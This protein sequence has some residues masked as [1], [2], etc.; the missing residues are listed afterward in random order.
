MEH[1]Q[2]ES[3]MFLALAIASALANPPAEAQPM[4]FEPIDVPGVVHAPT[5][6]VVLVQVSAE[7]V[8]PAL[9]HMEM[10]VPDV[11]DPSARAQ[12]TAPAPPR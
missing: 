8:L 6:P 3:A 1:T 2:P 9:T 12:V 5:Q 11:S 7:A 4:R 10:L